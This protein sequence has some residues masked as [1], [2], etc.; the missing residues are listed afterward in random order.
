MEGEEEDAGDE[1][2][3]VSSSGMCWL[4]NSRQ[5]TSWIAA[6]RMSSIFKQKSE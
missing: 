1:Y 5:P 6:L 2:D 4:K 3:V